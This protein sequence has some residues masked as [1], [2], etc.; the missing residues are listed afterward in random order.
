MLMY[1]VILPTVLVGL[2][3]IGAIIRDGNDNT[4]ITQ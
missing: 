4:D 2:A 1:I 3:V